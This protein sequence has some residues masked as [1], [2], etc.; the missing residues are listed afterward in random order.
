MAL[1]IALAALATS[2]WALMIVLR[3]G[4]RFRRWQRDTDTWLTSIER[5]EQQ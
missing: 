3:R 2:L 4:R 5:E 1:V